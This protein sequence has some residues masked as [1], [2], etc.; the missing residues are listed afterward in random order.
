MQKKYS[1][2]NISPGFISG[3]LFYCPNLQYHMLIYGIIC[4]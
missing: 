1:V 2:H 4:L 3:G